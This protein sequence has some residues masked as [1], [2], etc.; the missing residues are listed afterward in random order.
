MNPND[1]I[2][3]LAQCAICP[4]RAL[5]TVQL[6]DWVC[7]RCAEVV[8]TIANEPGFG[9]VDVAAAEPTIAELMAGIEKRRTERLTAAVADYESDYPIGQ[10]EG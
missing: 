3:Y 8:P 7:P 4:Q 6:D 5:L 9:D 2:G 1:V 10:V